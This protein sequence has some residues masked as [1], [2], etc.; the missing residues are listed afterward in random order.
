VWSRS[1]PHARE[2]F[3][4]QLLD[5]QLVRRRA[6]A[7]LLVVV[8]NQHVPPRLCTRE[9]VVVS[10]CGYHQN[11]LRERTALATY[12]AHFVVEHLHSRVDEEER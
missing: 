2:R 5:G 1:L 12:V 6:S 8:H 3:S 10:T 4:H 7:K 9:G 11:G